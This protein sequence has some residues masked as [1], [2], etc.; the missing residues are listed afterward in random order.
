MC[1]V[2]TD[3]DGQPVHLAAPREE[4]ISLEEAKESLED[5]RQQYPNCTLTAEQLNEFERQRISRWR[6]MSVEQLKKE[7]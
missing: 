5:F 2:F 1:V 4:K 6:G 7:G 3:K